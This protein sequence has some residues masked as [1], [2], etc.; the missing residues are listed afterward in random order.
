MLQCGV[1]LHLG[2]QGRDTI[3]LLEKARD[4]GLP[5]SPTIRGCQ[6]RAGHGSQRPAQPLG[7]DRE[8]NS[9]FLK[10]T[11]ADGHCWAIPLLEGVQGG[12][13]LVHPASLCLS[14]NQSAHLLVSSL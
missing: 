5:G 3:C 11:S 12:Q 4:I 6:G 9:V 13:K 1:D 14:A 10:Q 2:G 7:T 8:S